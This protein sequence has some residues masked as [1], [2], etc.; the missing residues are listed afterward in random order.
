M[1]E[2]LLDHFQ[3]KKMSIDDRF[4]AGKKLR[5]KFN[6][7]KQDEY[8][9]PDNRIDPISILEEQAKTRLPELI[10]VRYARMLTSPFA[11]LRG[12]ALFAIKLINRGCF[13]K[14]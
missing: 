13:L 2:K 14:I 7:I 1:N 8:K 11:F 6:R 4:S 10:P 3:S 5:E 12:G 9:T